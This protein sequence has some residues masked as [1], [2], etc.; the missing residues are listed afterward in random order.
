MNDLMFL[1]CILC[2]RLSILHLAVA[3]KDCS[4]EI[5]CVD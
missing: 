2:I 1:C 3:G 5:L 4:I